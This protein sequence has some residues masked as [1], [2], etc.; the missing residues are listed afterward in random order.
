[1]KTLLVAGSNVVVSAPDVEPTRA[2]RLLAL[3]TLIV[4][5]FFLSETAELADIVLPVL[6]W[7]E[8]EGTMTS[9]EG[10]VIRRR[11][12]LPGPDGARSELWI[13]SEIARRL[14]AASTWSTDPAEVFDELARASEGGIADYSGLSHALLDTGVEAYWPYRS[15]STRVRSPSVSRMPTAAH[16]SYRW[17]PLPRRPPTAA[18]T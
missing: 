16:A 13:L 3:D 1:M 15:E 17:M 6:Q 2:E 18:A 10:R 4:C 9:L 5:D 12:A 8:E 7:A 11:Q 14:G